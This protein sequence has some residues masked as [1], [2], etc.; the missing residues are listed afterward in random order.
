MTS[1]SRWQRHGDDSGFTLLE[2]IVGMT[3]LSIFMAIFGG[4][5]IS[6]FHSATRTQQT[7]HA[8]SQ[9]N[10]VFL[11]LDRE[12]RYASAISVPA[13]NQFAGG[14]FVVE[15]LT[16]YTDIP[17]CTELRLSPSGDLQQRTWSQGILS[18]MSSPTLLATGIHA[19]VP[20]FTT[21]P[22]ASTAGPFAVSQPTG[23]VSNQRL[24]VSLTSSDPGPG[25]RIRATDVTFTAL[26]TDSSATVSTTG[27]VCGEGRKFTWP[28]L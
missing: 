23:T 11:T 28:G 14:D 2:V 10:Q 16:S 19:G 17:T 26:N 9:A 24:E 13:A 12:V 7:S 15:F 27:T 5:L 18:T 1:T 4:S 22:S 20:G 25:A 3:I 6:M 8:Q 21:D